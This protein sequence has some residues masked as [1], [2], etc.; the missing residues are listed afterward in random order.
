LKSIKG[1]GGGDK[2]RRE[3]GGGT[4]EEEIQ[5]RLVVQLRGHQGGGD[6]VVVARGLTSGAPGRRRS[7]GGAEEEEILRGAGDQ[8]WPTTAHIKW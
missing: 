6:P 7:I 1:D 3:K 4:R 8:V 5:W 2:T